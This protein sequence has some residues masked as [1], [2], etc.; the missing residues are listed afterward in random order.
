MNVQENLPVDRPKVN[1]ESEKMRSRREHMMK[2]INDP[3]KLK[4]E[5]IKLIREN[6]GMEK[7][8]A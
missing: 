4:S 6:M 8:D 1:P 5:A 7:N 2:F 3:E